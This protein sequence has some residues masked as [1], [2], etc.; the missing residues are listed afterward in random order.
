MATPT[1]ATLTIF[2]GD[3][4]LLWRHAPTMATRTY[5]GDTRLLW[6]HALTMATRA[7]Y[8]YMRQL[9]YGY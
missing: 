1:V 9:L 5:Y 3:T 2:Y 7:Y 4:H 8:G 6:L